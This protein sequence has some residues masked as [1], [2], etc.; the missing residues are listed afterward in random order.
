M[1][2]AGD[3]LILRYLSNEDYMPTLESYLTTM[4]PRKIKS[5]KQLVGI[6]NRLLLRG[7]QSDTS[8]PTIRTFSVVSDFD[9]TNITMKLIL[10]SDGTPFD[11]YVELPQYI[12]A[13]ATSKDEQAT[14]LKFATDTIQAI[15]KELP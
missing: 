13:L 3:N 11:A 12:T 9:T 14:Y 2:Q 6:V 4:P 5:D 15:A 10:D 8:Y 7:I 1:S